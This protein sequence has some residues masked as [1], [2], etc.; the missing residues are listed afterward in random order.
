MSLGAK[1]IG[2]IISK[3]NTTVGLRPISERRIKQATRNK[4]YEGLSDKDR[5]EQAHREVI[6]EFLECE[7]GLSKEELDKV[8]SFSAFRPVINT[9]DI[10]Y[11]KLDSSEL[12]KI[13]TRKAINLDGHG[14][15]QTENPQ[16]V[17]YIPKE[18]YLRYKALKQHCK[19]LRKHQTQP[20]A[21]SIGLS[22]QDFTLKQWPAKGHPDW[23]PDSIPQPW[24]YIDNSPLPAGLPE[25]KLTTKKVTNNKT[26]TTGRPKTPTSPAL[27]EHPSEELHTSFMDEEV[28]DDIEQLQMNPDSILTSIMQSASKHN[29]EVTDP[30]KLMP[31]PPPPATIPKR[32]LSVNSQG[33]SE[34]NLRPQRYQRVG[35]VGSVG[36]A[37]GANNGN[38]ANGA[39]GETANEDNLTIAD[40]HQADGTS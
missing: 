17:R 1:R 39:N 37:N 28:E 27:V 22:N 13:I 7:M 15:S 9:N 21:T 34:L 18:L 6:N 19:D 20:M 40:I 35:S 8:Q 16:M 33:S 36:S 3:A 12:R 38:S 4:K 29:I 24:I 5:N 32:P 11:I 30:A 10:T 26:I 2:E 14:R 31:P 25:I 23:N